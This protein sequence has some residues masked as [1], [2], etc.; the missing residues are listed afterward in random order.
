MKKILITALLG[1]FTL[2]S[3]G[4]SINEENRTI[5]YDINKDLYI[6]HTDENNYHHVTKDGVLHGRFSHTFN[7]IVVIGN[8]KNGKRHGSIVTYVDDKKISVIKYKDG[9]VL[10]ITN[11]L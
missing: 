6:V 10:A 7:N 9:E 4:Q 3:N 5:A 11:I 8:M 2:T 1:L